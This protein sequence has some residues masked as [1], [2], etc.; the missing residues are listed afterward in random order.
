MY[1]KKTPPTQEPAFFVGRKHHDAMFFREPLNGRV[2]AQDR[3]ET[4]DPFI[5]VAALVKGQHLAARIDDGPP[6]FRPARHR[7]QHREGALP[8]QLLPVN[9]LSTLQVIH[10]FIWI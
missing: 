6:V 10:G 2:H 7:G 3:T 8:G 4:L 5:A 1:P 9:F